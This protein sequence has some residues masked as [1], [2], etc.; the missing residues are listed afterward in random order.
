MTAS[1]GNRHIVKRLVWFSLGLLAFLAAVVVLL[2]VGF[3]ILQSLADRKNGALV[4]GIVKDQDDQPLS[5]VELKFRTWNWRWYIPIPF[6]PTRIV[7]K[8]VT[9]VSGADGTFSKKASLPRS[10]FVSAAKP[11]FRQDGT[12]T[13]YMWRPGAYTQ[14]T[15]HLFDETRIRK[16][17]LHSFELQSIPFP[18]DRQIGLNLATGSI[19]PVD[20]ADIVFRWKRLPG[21]TN[22]GDYGKYVIRAV[23]GGLWFWEQERLFAPKEGYEDGMIYFYDPGSLAAYMKLRRCEFFAMSR[24]GQMYAR[25]FAQLDTGNSTLS[26]R[27][28]VNASGNRFVD[29]KSE[30]YAVGVYGSLSPNYLNPG[31]PWWLDQRPPKAQVIFSEKR[32]REL[33][34]NAP[35][36]LPFPEYFAGHYQTPGNVL[37]AMVNGP[38]MQNHYVVQNLAKNYAAPASVLQQL[39]TQLPA[40][41]TKDVDDT[42]AVPGD[43]KR[44]LTSPE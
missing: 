37:A 6:A 34:S 27:A 44:F 1:Q 42:L 23:N 10:E 4:T 33:F 29:A 32:A 11:G 8:E 35:A 14:W 16:E 24:D 28:R 31:V 43:L 18:A 39:K 7:S 38:L 3:Q 20:E 21:N 15:L 26:L 9:V 36:K 30:T 17:Q 2:L 41:Q 5:G 12:E 19:S 25:V 13:D 22:H 40:S